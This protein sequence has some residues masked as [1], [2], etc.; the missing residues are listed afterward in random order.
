MI[1]K[2][3][4]LI[5]LFLTKVIFSQDV[6]NGPEMADTWRNDGKIYVVIGVMSVIFGCVI[7]YLAIIERKLKKLEEEIKEKK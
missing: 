3:S 6:S 2:L 1:K 7:I 4:L 5:F